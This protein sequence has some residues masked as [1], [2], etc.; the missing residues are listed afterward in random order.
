MRKATTYT[1]ITIV[2]VALLVC[3]G[4]SN[5]AHAVTATP[6]DPNAATSTSTGGADTSGCSRG[7]GNNNS[8]NGNSSNTSAQ[9]SANTGTSSTGSKSQNCW[10]EQ[11]AAM[12]DVLY[13]KPCTAEENAANTQA[14]SKSPGSS[15]S[16]DTNGPCGEQ[17][18]GS[19]NRNSEA[20]RKQIWDFFVNKFKEDF[21]SRGMDDAAAT[22]QA[23]IAAAGV[24][25]NIEQESA[26]MPDAVNS[27]GCSGI[28][29]WCF[30]RNDQMR[31]FAADRGKDWTCLGTQLDFVWHE[32]T[33][34]GEAGVMDGMAS[35]KTPG[36]AGD[37]WAVEYERM[38]SDEQAGR[39][40]RAE[41][42]YNEYTGKTSAIQSGAGNSAED[43]C[44]TG[45]PASTN[46]GDGVTTGEFG[47]PMDNATITE[48]YGGGLRGGQGHYAMDWSSTGGTGA[49]GPVKSV[50][51]GEVVAVSNN[52]PP[53]SG[54]GNT[55]V[56]KHSNGYYSRYSHLDS[57]SV[58]VG[59]KVSKGQQIGV[60]G[61]TGSSSG[62][63]LDF[64]ISKNP[65]VPNSAESE[66]PMK[67]IKL[68][69][70]VNN[71]ANCTPDQT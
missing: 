46:Q 22:R 61:N 2:F 30:S 21:K 71:A 55:V 10:D 12:N 14:A 24:L 19:G 60:E 65:N 48:C 11:F 32:V 16:G 5:P 59:D 23:E 41:K 39:A 9:Q 18:Y 53:F 64:G 42:I 54:F 34:T 36:E 6:N 52:E 66:N 69:N 8:S 49:G 38:R 4:S 70:G 43:D 68:E 20:N 51:G 57:T 40:E 3:I 28:V 44:E 26:F 29:Q 33:Q 56:V 13:Y 1:R 47:M 58:N 45:A 31:Q 63:H 62:T 35:A 17:G 25:G 50:D 67:F 37:T 27:L 7:S 15:S